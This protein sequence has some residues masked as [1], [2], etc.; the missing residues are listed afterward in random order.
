M[1]GK[2]AGARGAVPKSETLLC[3]LCGEG[4]VEIA[5]AFPFRS[6]RRL[7]FDTCEV[8]IATCL[9]QPYDECTVYLY[10]CRTC[11]LE[12]YPPS[13][14]GTSRLYQALG[15]FSYYYSGDRWEFDM[16]AEDIKGCRNVLEI[17]CGAGA[18]LERL[19]RE[20]PGRTTVGLELNPDAAQA[21]CDKGLHVEARE[22]EEFAVDHAEAFDVVCGFQVLEHVPAPDRFL[23][24]A[25]RCLRPGGLCLLAVP[26]RE[27]FTSYAV[28]DFG[29]MPPHHL[30]RWSGGVMRKI[31]VRYEAT[32]ERIL[33]GP[34]AEYHKAW[35][36]DTLTVRAVSAF[37]GFRWGRV[38]MGTRYRGLLGLCQRLQRLI[39]ERLWRYNRYP[40]HT[41]YVAYRKSQA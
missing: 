14:Y 22:V 18:F 29:N 13:L 30:T 9:E 35:Y 41:M 5:E 20:D 27:G 37:F 34:T 10:R 8:D 7:W 19:M 26:N 38:E 28:N 31:A 23:K 33:E 6:L 1:S 17:G 3:S 21:A 36:R 4:G 39:P 40:G 16:A 15:K 25:F 32:V 12:F 11:E 2:S 24:A